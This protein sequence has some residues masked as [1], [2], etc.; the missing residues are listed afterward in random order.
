VAI[1]ADSVTHLPP[2]NFMKRRAPDLDGK[3]A[4][5]IGVPSGSN[6]HAPGVMNIEPNPHDLMSLQTTRPPDALVKRR[7]SSRVRKA[8]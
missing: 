1:F 4:C 8:G 2:H 3:T 5:P 7:A 6:M